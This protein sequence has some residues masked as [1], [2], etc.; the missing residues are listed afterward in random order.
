[1]VVAAAVVVDVALAVNAKVVA[2]AEVVDLVV[3][4]LL[5]LVVTPLQTVFQS[6][7]IKLKNN[8]QKSCFVCAR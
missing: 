7:R 6:R 5:W 8:S 4:S 1:M 3:L 2:E